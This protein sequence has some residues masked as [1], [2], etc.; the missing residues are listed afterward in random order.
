MKQVI[1]IP[2]IVVLLVM[3]VC[4]AKINRRG[5]PDSPRKLEQQAK[6]RKATCDLAGMLKN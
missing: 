2:L 1:S 4:V 6:L 5:R 3:P